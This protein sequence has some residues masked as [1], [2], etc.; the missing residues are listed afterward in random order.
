MNETPEITPT[1]VRPWTK[2]QVCDHVWHLTDPAVKPR[3]CP[4][5]KTTLWAATRWKRT[6]MPDTRALPEGTIWLCC[7]RCGHQWFTRSGVLPVRCPHP[8]CGSPYWH[9]PRRAKVAA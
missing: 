2:C 8:K 3:D 9:R 6:A 7:A 5:C 1:T 4:N